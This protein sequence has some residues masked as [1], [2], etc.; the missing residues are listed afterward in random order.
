MN[1]RPRQIVILAANATE[2]P[3]DGG[4]LR[5]LAFR[6]EFK[7]SGLPVLWLGRESTDVPGHCDLRPPRSKLAAALRSVLQRTNYV[8][9]RHVG[10]DW[11]AAAARVAVETDDHTVVWQNFIWS[12]AEWNR[13]HGRGRVFI[14]THNSERE[15]FENI[16]AKTRNPLIRAVARASIS[17][18]EELVRNLPSTTTLIHVSPSDFAYYSSLAPHCRHAVVAN[19]C[20]IRPVRRLPRQPGRPRLYFLGSLGVQMNLDALR[21]F[22]SRFWPALCGRSEF[23][24]FGSSP[25]S[26]VKVLC[27]EM[28]WPLHA[29]LH[30]VELDRRLIDYDV[31]VMPFAYTAGSK[32]KLTDALIRGMHVLTT[33]EG[34]R[35]AENLPPTVMIGAAGADWVKKLGTMDLE[36]HRA[37]ELSLA[38]ARSFTWEKIVD[39]FL[40]SQHSPLQ[41]LP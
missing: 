25:S 35:G 26:S 37:V 11:R 3:H 16:A 23:S 34:A 1:C 21:N 24:V 41:H 22:S 40:R 9:E 4:S 6:T 32:L 20:Q 39:S 31:A 18:S 15:W 14:D 36:D 13:A 28:G 30:D 27:Q 19:G 38:Y 33:P 5:S 29:D 7:R 12:H 2:P 8:G 10:A 17:A